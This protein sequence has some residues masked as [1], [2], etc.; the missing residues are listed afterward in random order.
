[1]EKLKGWIK[2]IGFPIVMSLLLLYIVFVTLGN[3][4]TAINDLLTWLQSKTVTITERY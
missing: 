2:D 1:M 4:T 3:N